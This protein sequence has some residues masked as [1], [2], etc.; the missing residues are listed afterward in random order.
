MSEDPGATVQQVRPAPAAAPRPA[1]MNLTGQSLPVR[2]R[3]WLG[4]GLALL[5]LLSCAFLVDLRQ[6]GRAL[7]TLTPGAITGLLLLATA[8]RLL[9]GYK[10]GRLLRIVGVRTPMPRLIRIFYRANLSGVFLP[11]HVGGDLLRAWWAVQ[12]TG[13]RYPI[14]AS[15]VVER[16][17]GLIA[18]VNWALLGGTVYA[19]ATLPGPASRWFGAGLAAALAANACFALLLSD[20]LHAVVLAQLDRHRGTRPLQ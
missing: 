9:M 12:A 10:W 15:L 2:R 5:I 16:V 19:V 14:F 3:N 7:L 1:A 13:L 11:S 17:L 4:W 8:D 6:L 18:A 20:R